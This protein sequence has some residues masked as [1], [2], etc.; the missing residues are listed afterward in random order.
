MIVLVQF[1]L[2]DK[3]KTKLVVLLIP[4]CVEDIY[5]GTGV[6]HSTG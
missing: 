2:V 5:K 6:Y 4:V 3:K 1:V